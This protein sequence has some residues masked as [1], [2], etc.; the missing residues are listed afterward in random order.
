MKGGVKVVV[1]WIIGGIL[2]LA[3]LAIVAVLIGRLWCR[4]RRIKEHERRPK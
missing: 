4:W 2:V 3:W 1:I